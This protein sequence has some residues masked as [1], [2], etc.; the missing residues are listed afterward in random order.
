VGL[1]VLALA[2][3]V[4]AQEYLEA[5]RM[6]F[7]REQDPIKKARLVGKLGNAQLAEAGKAADAGNYA[8]AMRLLEEYRDT[9]KQAY[10][11][12]KATGRDA[13]REPAGFKQ[14]QIH[15]RQ[16]IRKVDH[17]ITALP[18]ARRE[19]FGSLRSELAALDKELLSVLFPRQPGG[20]KS[21]GKPKGQG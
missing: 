14:L 8:Q 6:G 7:A 2:G 13:E 3:P 9:V 17:L 10:D 15:V 12:L 19:P 18:F 21:N 11:G 20:N 4:G 5:L 16:S 1:S